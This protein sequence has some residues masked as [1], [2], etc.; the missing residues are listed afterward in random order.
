[1]KKAMLWLLMT[2]LLILGM[3]SAEIKTIDLT[4]G[5]I[6]LTVGRAHSV[7][8]KY[9]DYSYQF[10]GIYTKDDFNITYST[11]YEGVTID[12]DGTIHVSEEAPA[13]TIWVDVTY[14][15]KKRPSDTRTNRV[16]SVIMVEAPT[17]LVLSRELVVMTM[18]DGS[19]SVRV[20]FPY[21]ARVLESVS[22]DNEMLEVKVQTTAYTPSTTSVIF[23]PLQV[24]E[25]EIVVRSLNN[26]VKTLKVVVV[27]QPT[28]FEMGV[29]RAQCYVGDDVDLQIDLGNGPYGKYGSSPRLSVYEAG[30]IINNSKLFTDDYDFHALYGGTYEVKLLD[31]VGNERDSAIIEVYDRNACAEI[32]LPA[33][34]YV[35]GTT[36][37][38]TL[39]DQNGQ[40]VFQRVSCTGA[41]EVYASR[42][43]WYLTPTEA[44]EFTVTVTNGDGTVCSKT[45]TALSDKPTNLTIAASSL[46]MQIG[47]VFDLNPTFNV[48]G[49]FICEYTITDY[50]SKY[51]YG[52]VCI[53]VE[54]DKIIAQGP[55][56]ARISV[57]YGGMTRDCVVTVEDS[58]ARIGF[59]FSESPLGVG[60]TV[61]V[62]VQDQT[63]KIYP[64]TFGVKNGS[65]SVTSD[66]RLTGLS[67]GYYE[68]YAELEDG[69]VLY[70]KNQ[71]V[72][73]YP[74]WLEYSNL[75]ITM[76]SYVSAGRIQ[77]DQGL[78]DWDEVTLTI[79]D[80]SI[81]YKSGSDFWAQKA[82]KT[83]A[84]ITSKYS[85]ASCTFQIEVI[86]NKLYVGSTTIYVPYGFASRLPVVTNASGNEV[87]MAWKITQNTP[88][89]GNPNDSAFLLEDNIISCLWPEGSCILTGTGYN[90]ATVRVNVYAYYLPDTL[91]ITPWVV[92]MN[93]GESRT[94]NVTWDDPNAQVKA[95]YWITDVD[96]I[97]SY[98]ANATSTRISFTGIAGGTVYVM[99][100][101]DN[102]AYAI[103]QINVTNP[104][105]RLPGD[106]NEDGKVDIH[107][108]LLV[109]QYTAGWYVSI[110]GYAADVNADNRVTAEDAILI[111]Q[112]ASGLN[113]ELR[114]YI[115]AS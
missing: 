96:G 105:A 101:L 25:S 9:G 87:A 108:A 69:R 110:N 115:P 50:N 46:T 95:V 80:P 5:K 91:D 63:G 13:G 45:F 32:S 26:L 70:S 2:L 37:P 23:T 48:P 107:D 59:V 78:I 35:V 21:G 55:G 86:D 65:V 113:V 71:E 112:Y 94:L 99:A 64:A 31:Y 20:D 3:A 85:G 83:T 106:A 89:E 8:P 93:V 92:N 47:E 12:A 104:Y 7:L 88:G 36:Y 73:I 17:K 74:E 109:M 111:F 84:T 28:K 16:Y 10:G 11:E 34:S 54:D 43:Q 27:N 60:R 6:Y 62:T 15:F 30:K 97:V 53:R 103:C 1:M 24:G 18:S 49:D 68:I 58:D 42:G 114:Q 75:F 52:I 56:K 40:S 14:S 77:T 4:N 67:A 19:K 22:Y 82:G 39:K 57:K 29:E 100:L 44:G 76:G 41:A 66:G 33:G 61:R 102:G 98:D 51:D 90:G 38:L 72:F 81:A 79:D